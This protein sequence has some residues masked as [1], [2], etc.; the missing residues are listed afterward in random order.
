MMETDT[1]TTT[2][3]SAEEQT[4][5]KPDDLVLGYV[6]W[7]LIGDWKRWVRRRVESISY[8]TATSVRRRV[9]VDLRLIPELFGSPVVSWGAEKVHYVPIALLH[10]QRLVN[11]DLRDEDGQALPLITKH[12]NATIAAA[13][14]SVAARTVVSHSLE[15]AAVGWKVDDPSVIEIPAWLDR[16]FWDL[17]YLNPEPSL[18]SGTLETTPGAL[19]TAGK[20]SVAHI[21]GAQPVENWDWTITDTS[22]RTTAS[23]RDWRGL[24]AT[25]PGFLRM[26]HDVAQTFMICVPLAHEEGRRRIVKFGYSEDRGGAESRPAQRIK[27]AAVKIHLARKWNRWEDWLEGL[28]KPSG[29]APEEWTPSLATD[30]AALTPFRRKLFQAVGWTTEIGKFETPALRH[31]SSYHLNVTTPDGIQIRRAQLISVDA[32]G[33]Q[34]KHPPQRGTRTLRSVDLHVSRMEQSHK[35]GY[36]SLNFRAESSLIIRAGFI[37]SL[38]TASALTLVWLYA[39]NIM[40]DEGQHTDA[41][42]AALVVIPGLLAVLAARDTDHPLT[43]HMTFG[44]RVVAMLPG[45]LAVLAAGAVI[46]SDPHTG[47]PHADYHHNWF[48]I[49]LFAIAW[50]VTVLFGVAW[51]LA[52]R[53]RPDPDSIP[54]TV[55]LTREK[56]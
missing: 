54:S 43:T 8:E 53:G 31:G 18:T 35:G 40:G 14:L 49:L 1:H 2:A 46:T 3:L 32:S 52:S 51:R 25:D 30:L 27:Q 44:L 16:D 7:K 17:A 4:R 39:R 19:A 22:L 37:S 21:A 12:R 24:L 45:V 41:V 55:E 48:G 10:K 47:H 29:R 36:A 15:E 13:M 50:L 6:A 20:F 56:A 26:A 9:S 23:E 5:F 28:P 42:A 34:L 38:L 33:R 11:F